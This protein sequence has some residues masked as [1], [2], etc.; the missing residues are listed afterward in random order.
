MMDWTTTIDAES[1]VYGAKH[2]ITMWRKS[3]NTD[4]AQIAQYSSHA[5]SAAVE[6][7]DGNTVME[8]INMGGVRSARPSVQYAG[9]RCVL[10]TILT[11]NP[12]AKAA[13]SSWKRD[14]GCSSG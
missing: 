10:L 9:R 12:T 14:S 2:A 13:S 8:L 3:M 4:A 6:R 5:Q 1:A 11:T 7:R